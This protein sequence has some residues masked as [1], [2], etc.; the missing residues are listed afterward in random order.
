MFRVLRIKHFIKSLFGAIFFCGFAIFLLIYSGSINDAKAFLTKPVNLNELKASDIRDGVR[1]KADISVIYDYYCHYE[2]DGKITS[3]EYLIPVGYKEYMGL[4]CDGSDMEEA[5]AIM[6]SYW[7]HLD[8]KKE[9]EDSNIKP[10][11]IK[12][13]IV[14]L[15]GEEY[16][17]YRQYID[18]IDVPKMARDNFLPYA[19]MVGKIGT[20][21]KGTMIIY[22]IFMLAL[23]AG[24]IT[25]LY[26]G[27][28]GSN[29]K[30]VEKYCREQGDKELYMRQLED[31]YASGIPVQGIRIDTQYFM[32]VKDA[33][34][35]F[36]E[37]DELLWVYK[38][39]IQHRV[40]GIP[41]G[42]T[43]ALI[44]KKKNGEG[45]DIPMKN[46]RA[47]DEAIEYV[48]Q[49]LPYVIL[50][51]HADLAKIY[52]KERSEMIYEVEKR[53]QEHLGADERQTSA[54]GSYE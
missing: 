23:F 30:Q 8:G 6:Q 16:S 39:I 10:M 46:E 5:D 53:Q 52:R 36:A 37:C 4:V 21:S 12:G 49:K 35:F 50:G 20:H 28:T 38:K 25:A 33:S 27:I 2:E 44:V 47:A 13:T 24:G 42:K 19:I 3:K 18:E 51:Y 43:Y 26:G 54:A 31:F 41:T 15:G 29:L 9:S 14:A 45:F 7:D 48:S 40:N 34:C 32:A 22:W 1:V 11:K 17:M